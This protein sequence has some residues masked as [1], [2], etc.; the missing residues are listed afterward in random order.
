MSRFL[1]LAFCLLIL[2]M[3]L[4]EFALEILG[5]MVD[6]APLVQVDLARLEAVPAWMTLGSWVLE[7]MALTALF[8]LIQGRSGSWVMDGLATGWIAW[9]F[10]GPLL[11]LTLAATTRL[12]QE[13]WWSMTLRWWVL[14]TL[15]G[16][17][18]SG[19]GRVAR[20]ER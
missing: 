2:M 4:Y 17:L 14:Y 20:L 13:P 1:F 19:L 18:L 10:R 16:L 7:A 12:P 8:L 6:S 9:V 5:L 11:V 3:G 15:C